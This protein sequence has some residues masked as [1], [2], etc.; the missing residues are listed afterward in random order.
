ML[1]NL[2]SS[3][4]LIYAMKSYTS[5]N[6]VIDEF[7]EDIK[8]VKY[9]KRLIKRYR[10]TGELKERL[11]LNHIILLGNVFGIRAAVRIL[12]YKVNPGDYGILKPFLLYLSYL[13][14]VVYG[15][16]GVDINTS[17][18][19]MDTEVTTRLRNV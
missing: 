10:D 11:I 5:P 3:N 4:F 12:F 19:V 15:I 9:I 1:D 17:E 13:P 2:D 7:Q 6:C 16:K 18:I 14:E 8:K